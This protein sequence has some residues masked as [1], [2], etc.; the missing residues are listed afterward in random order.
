MSDQERQPPGAPEPSAP[1]PPDE[2]DSDSLPDGE[3][4]GWGP[5]VKRR[6][7]AP[8]TPPKST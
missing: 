6:P 5:I 8:P 2:T 1:T 4:D 3:H 7:S